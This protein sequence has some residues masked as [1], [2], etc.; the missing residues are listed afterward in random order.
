MY[1][2]MD[3]L[4]VPS[5]WQLLV[6]IAIIITVTV[7]A[8]LMARM[9]LF[10][11]AQHLASRTKTDFDDKLLGAARRPAY[12]MVYLLGFG[13]LVQFLQDREL[14][15]LSE[16]VFTIV[17]GV[18]FTFGVLIIA[19]MAVRV[20]STM[21]SW[22]GTNVASRTETKIDDEF[23]PLIDRAVKVI[24]Y[25]L[26][27]LV[28]LDHF[29]VNITGLITVLGVGSL[30]IAL[31]AQDTIANMIG[32]FVIMIDRPFRT[33]DRLLLDDGRVCDVYQIGVRSTKFQ[34]RENTLIIVPNAELTK[35][36]VHNLSYPQTE[37]RIRVDVGVGY[38]ED[39][40]QVRTVML[41]EA[42]KHTNIIE[43]PAPQFRFL[44]FGDSALDVSLRCRVA[45]VT[46]QYRTESELRQQVLRRFRVEGIEIPFP[47]RVVTMIADDSTD[48]ESKASHPVLDDTPISH[49]SG[50]DDGD[51]DDD[52]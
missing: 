4:A 46:T 27:V 34:T 17:D 32:G 36:T 5:Q 1:E 30:A 49:G 35:S 2:F 41:D 20:L 51:D 47:Q 39:L 28:I 48:D 15:Y 24:L 22:F 37:T 38:G 13:Y 12:L 52:D 14:P 31:A 23:M 43:H 16:A 10:V 8:V 29:D 9:L 45:D 21:I 19:H 50:T 7:V 6:G 40:D 3:Y 42:S 33:G 26:G 11:V 18:I 44:N 25:V